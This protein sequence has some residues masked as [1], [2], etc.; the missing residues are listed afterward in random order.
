[1]A[2]L[3]L[4]AS[5]AA[6]CGLEVQ[7][8]AP[9]RIVTDPTEKVSVLRHFWGPIF[10]LH[11]VLDVDGADDFVSGYRNE[12][13]WSWEMCLYRT[14]E[15]FILYLESLANTAPGIDGIPNAAW[16]ALKGCD[17]IIR[18]FWDLLKVF[19]ADNP[20][21]I[22]VGFNHGLMV[23]IPK[24]VGVVTEAIFAHPLELR[25]QTLKNSANKVIAGILNWVIHPAVKATA[26]KLQNRFVQ[27]LQLV[28]NAVDLD[29]C[30]RVHALEFSARRDHALKFV[31]DLKI[32]KKGIVAAIPI[33]L[34][35]DFA[36]AFPSVKHAWLHLILELI[37][38]PLEVRRPL[39][40]M[41]S[42]NEAFVDC[43]GELRWL[44]CV[45]SGVL[46]GCPLSGPLFVIVIDPLLFMFKK[47]VEDI[48]VGR[49]RAR[50]D[51]IGASLAKLAKIGIFQ[52]AFARFQSV[53]GLTLKPKK[54]LMV[55]TASEASESNINVIRL[56]L[57][58]NC[59]EWANFQITNSG[60]Y[61]GFYLG[62]K[63]AVLQWRDPLLKF[64]A[65][66]LEAKQATVRLALAGGN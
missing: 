36:A 13:Q 64:K 24:A 32:E 2:G 3:K 4:D 17:G 61:L 39:L 16:K 28:Q 26:C 51:D 11:S 44:F 6:A 5:D 60:K 19:T 63:T 50:A 65:R 66:T 41:Y 48:T 52:Q 54:C 29:Q 38:M 21:G 55:L 18:Y 23:F 10:A 59:P 40:N 62:P 49:V 14:Y 56:W 31:S 1:M 34:L 30:A 9:E 53:S 33:L 35:F 42:G 22:P 12:V 15:T 58:D 27:G 20:G 57:K 8:D 45:I 47:K 25:P 43:D 7:K 37:K 46:Q